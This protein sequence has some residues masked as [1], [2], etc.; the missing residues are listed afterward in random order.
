MLNFNINLR[1][2]SI[3]AT[4]NVAFGAYVRQD[5]PE[6]KQIGSLK[7]QFFPSDSISLPNRLY[8]S[9]TVSVTSQGQQSL[10]SRLSALKDNLLLNGLLLMKGFPKTEVLQLITYPSADYAARRVQAKQKEG[11][12]RPISAGCRLFSPIFPALK[13][14]NVVKVSDTQALTQYISG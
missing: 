12:N 5:S 8:F 9:H 14:Q 7:E 11:T 3:K 4:N 10:L 13:R 1:C 2:L 6:A